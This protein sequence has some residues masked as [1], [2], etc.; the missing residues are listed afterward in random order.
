VFFNVLNLIQRSFREIST[1]GALSSVGVLV[2]LLVAVFWRLLV[3]PN[4]YVWFDHWDMC[5]LEIPRATFIANSIQSGRFPLWDPNVWGG[6][7]VLGSGQPGPL[8]PLT[9]LLEVLP[10]DRGKISFIALNGVFF[11]Q[12]LIMGYFALLFF[13][14]IGV[15][16][17]AAALG[18]AAFAAGGY[19][20]SL[21]WL[22]ISNAVLCIPAIA[23]FAVR[24]NRN[25]KSRRDAAWLGLALGVC[26]LSG[27]H[28]IPLVATYTLL[29]FMVWCIAT[30]AIQSKA[31][32]FPQ[33]ILFCLSIGTG[34]AISSVQT[35]P[36]LEFGRQAKRW[37]DWLPPSGGSKPFHMKFIS[38]TRFTGA[39]R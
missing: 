14:E 23:L 24:L 35:L 25:P 34:A 28:E 6:L 26:W 4:E 29:G 39:T 16:T 13:R 31:L 9:L 7:P 12:R 22:D 30:K 11:L 27:H 3:L 33:V 32:H 19:V 21:P 1:S 38:I 17:V 20:G 15:K 18:A 37:V 2:L 10:L 36:L 8:F 5:Q